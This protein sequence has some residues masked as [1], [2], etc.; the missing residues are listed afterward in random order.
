MN[1]SGSSDPASGHSF[2][3]SPHDRPSNLPASV[4]WYLS[5]CLQ[6]PFARPPRDNPGAPPLRYTIRNADGECVSVAEYQS[7]LASVKDAKIDLLSLPPVAS[8]TPAAKLN[9]NY[10]FYKT[11][12]AAELRAAITKL[13][14]DHAVLALCQG[15][16]K[17][18]RLLQVALR[19]Q[20]PD[21]RLGSFSTPFVPSGT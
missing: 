19:K 5:D 21:P 1:W 4:L 3:S 6:D 8:R 16:W 9:R 13:E 11:I 12:F 17:T 20:G 10:S 7:I 15:H 2:K 14:A 18:R